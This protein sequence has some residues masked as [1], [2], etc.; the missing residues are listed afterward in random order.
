MIMRNI[1]WLQLLVLMFILGGCSRNEPLTQEALEKELAARRAGV[2]EGIQDA[3]ASGGEDAPAIE[4]GTGQKPAEESPANET[5][6]TDDTGV[7]DDLKA[8]DSTKP[9]PGNP[10]A[11]P[12]EEP[13][14]DTEQGIV[15]DKQR[16]DYGIRTEGMPEGYTVPYDRDTDR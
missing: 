11:P 12:A 8:P 9:F 14:G 5:P 13:S 3:H 4:L 6:R 16:G 7:S 10:S 15:I 1:K 2:S